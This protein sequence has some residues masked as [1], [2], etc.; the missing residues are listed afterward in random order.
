M[1]IDTGF[2]DCVVSEIVEK[3]T[4]KGGVSQEIL[5]IFENEKEQSTNKKV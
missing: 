1:K 4:G 3:I 5:H 2:F